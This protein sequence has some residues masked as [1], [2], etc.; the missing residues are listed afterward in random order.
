MTV[1]LK[2]LWNDYGIGAILVLLIVAYGVSLFAKYLS[3][4]GMSGYETNNT[5]QKQYKNTN[6]QMS[7][8]VQPSEPLGQN[9]VFA[10]ANGAQTSMPGIPSSCSSPSIQNPAELLPKDS[11]SQWAQ[12]NPSGKGE[13]AN[14]NLLKAGYHIGIDT[15]GQTLRNANL[16]IRSE[17]PNPQLYVGPWNAST[18]EPDFMR[19]PLELGSGPQ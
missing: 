13:L 14:V 7:A 15:I 16:Q 4:K 5:M 9:E 19:P 1:S 3:S 11:N 12:L 8:S 6:S 18:I 2:K 17:P 10:S